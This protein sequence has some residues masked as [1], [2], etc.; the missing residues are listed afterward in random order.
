VPDETA[1]GY[2]IA[3]RHPTRHKDKFIIFSNMRAH[4]RGYALS[5]YEIRYVTVHVVLFLVLKIGRCGWVYCGY[6]AATPTLN[7]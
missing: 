1:A 5:S 7:D 3:L 4:I 2:S 6:F